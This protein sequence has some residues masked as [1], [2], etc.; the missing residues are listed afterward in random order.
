MRLSFDGAVRS[1]AAGMAAS[2]ILP[3]NEAPSGEEVAKFLLAT[4]ARMPDHLRLAVRCATLALDAWPLPTSRQPFHRL[5]PIARNE[6]I[7]RWEMSRIGPIRS[8]MT[9]YRRLAT[10]AVWAAHYEEQREAVDAG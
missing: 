3:N 8:V 6:Q 7:A 2:T 4:H 5:P 1:L 9:F 10:Y